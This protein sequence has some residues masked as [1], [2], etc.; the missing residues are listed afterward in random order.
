[1][2]RPAWRI[3]LIRTQTLASSQSPRSWTVKCR[4]VVNCRNVGGT[5]RNSIARL[6]AITGSADS[7][8]P[9]ANNTVFSIAAQSDGKI[10]ASGYFTG[11]NSIGGQTRD[12]IA[13]LDPTTGLADSFNPNANNSVF[14]ITVQLDG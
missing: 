1:M 8:D 5:G 10:L 9:S 6:D 13:R 2:P 7:F 4:K 14:S 3:R 12:N 11:V